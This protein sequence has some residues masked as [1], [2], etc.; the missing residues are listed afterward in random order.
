[1]RSPYE[2]RLSET[3]KI[4]REFVQGD[5]HLCTCPFGIV[6]KALHP[7]K[8]AEEL[9]LRSG[10]SLRTAAYELSGEREP[11]PQSILALMLNII[12]ERKRG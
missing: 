1:M 3:T 8:S 12:P 2:E 11:S 7:I 6:W 10:C 9:A 4:Q 5:A